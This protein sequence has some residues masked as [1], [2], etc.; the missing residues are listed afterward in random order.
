MYVIQESTQRESP[1]T[2]PV[3]YTTVVPGARPEMR[4]FEP[5]DLA[6]VQGSSITSS[7]LENTEA[8][9]SG[10]DLNQGW[11]AFWGQSLPDKYDV[12]S[13]KVSHSSSAD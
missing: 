4:L 1:F 2:L 9:G 11:Q 5:E 10:K 7:A 6:L 3:G 13:L 12:S 8:S